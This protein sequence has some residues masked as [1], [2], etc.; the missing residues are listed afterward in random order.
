MARRFFSR[1]PAVGRLE[2]KGLRCWPSL[3]GNGLMLIVWYPGVVLTRYPFAP[4][5]SGQLCC[6][7]AGV[8]SI[9][10][11]AVIRHRILQIS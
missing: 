6:S 5:T 3:A 8:Q 1:D 2:P 4:P 11:T 7:G 9:F 10:Q